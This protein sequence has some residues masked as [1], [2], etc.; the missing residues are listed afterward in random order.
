M[1]IS[2][3]YTIKN[4][5]STLSFDI[6]VGGIN[7]PRDI[8]SKSDLTLYGY[9]RTSWGQEVDQNFYKLVENFACRELTPNPTATPRTK[10]Q[11][12]GTSGI[13][14]PIHGQNWFNLTTSEMYVCSNPA[15][16]TWKHLI[17]EPYADSRYLKTTD[18]NAT[19]VKLDGSNTPTTGYITLNAN[20]ILDMH[21]ATKGYV[22]SATSSS[23]AGY[24]R[25]IGD[26]MT[27]DLLIT[28]LTPN[29]AFINLLI[30]G[31]NPYPEIQM[32]RRNGVATQA[33]FE[34][35]TSGSATNIDSLIVADGGISG[36]GNQ[37]SITF[38]GFSMADR[39]PTLPLQF[40]TKQYT[41][42][43]ISNAVSGVSS[44]IG[45]LAFVRTSGDTMSGALNMGA[46]K[47][48][49]VGTPTI[50]SDVTTKGYADGAYYAPWGTAGVT[51]T[52][53][54]STAAPSGGVNGDI[55]IRI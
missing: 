20:P 45:G 4:T 11:L 32:G 47:V 36:V 51:N 31:V 16:N 39:H 17:S 46:N 38:Y 44:A 23:V 42:T 55:W 35:W 50:A 27:G 15:T 40:A 52:V 13:N 8:D 14:K 34:F 21:A 9:G 41:D 12:G 26:T 30:E 25:K 5:D 43:A 53:R 28:R 6:N 54:V 10:T 33:A 19:L 29:T 3:K 48:T 24:V 18:A 22:D 37:G 49:N 1:A 7:S 2:A